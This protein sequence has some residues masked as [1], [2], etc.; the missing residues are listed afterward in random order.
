MKLASL[1]VYAQVLNC[2][3][4]YA[5]WRPSMDYS[6]YKI[7]ACNLVWVFIRRLKKQ[8]NFNELITIWTSCV[9]KCNHNTNIIYILLLF[10][11]Q[12]INQ[13]HFL[14]EKIGIQCVYKIKIK[15]YFTLW[16]GFKNRFNAVLSRK[17]QL[18]LPFFTFSVVYCYQ[19]MI[20][21]IFFWYFFLVHYQKIEA[22]GKNRETR[23]KQT[24]FSTQLIIH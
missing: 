6:V 18:K 15:L 4:Y 9:V 23:D 1:F 14:F 16:S 11:N 17:N 3:H 13:S 8:Q 22:S 2:N 21:T 19:Y 7:V 20:Y 5:Q 24:K 12:P 10:S